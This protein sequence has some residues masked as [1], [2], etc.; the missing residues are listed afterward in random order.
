MTKWEFPPTGGHMEKNTGVYFQ[1]MTSVDAQERLK[2]NDLIMIP[3]GCTENHG[4]SGPY[5]EDTF[6]EARMCELVAE[7]TGCTVAQPIWYGAHPYQHLGMPGTIVIP[8]QIMADYLT[9]ILAGFWNAG[10]RKMILVNGHG[11]DWVIPSAIHTFGKKFQVPA[12]ITYPHLWHI[13]KQ[14]L[15][16]KARGGVYEKNLTHA[17]EVE[18]SWSLNLFPE[19]CQHE[20][21][22]ET[23]GTSLFPPGHIDFADELGTNG[24][25]K[26][27]NAYGNCGMEVICTPEGIIGNPKLASAEK[28]R[29]GVESA[30]DYL[31]KLVNDIMTMYPAGKLPPIDKV[32]QYKQEDIEAVIKGPTNG[33]R[34]IYTLTY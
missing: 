11:Q 27:Y 18:Q 28:G 9:Y 20:N 25:I 23:Q 14:E 21:A 33:G 12:V 32:T 4:P 10:F 16:T 22:V 6:L 1:N 5:G 7:A 30:L 15:G 13:G 34:H 19:L 26:W 17:C 2:K 3:V 24:P 29:A 8:D 31:E